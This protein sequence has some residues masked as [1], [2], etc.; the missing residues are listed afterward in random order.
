MIDASFSCVRQEGQCQLAGRG[1]AVRAAQRPRRGCA[2]CEAE[3]AHS[4][5]PIN[6]Q[7]PGRGCGLYSSPTPPEALHAVE[8]TLLLGRMG[9]MWV[10]RLLLLR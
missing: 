10:R 6:A 2:C 4:P 1:S 8:G 9:R 3:Q 5:C 7:R